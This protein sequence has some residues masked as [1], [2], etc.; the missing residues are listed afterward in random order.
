MDGLGAI[1]IGL[2]TCVMI[3]RVWQLVKEFV[4]SYE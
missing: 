3:G 1:A 2:V 4:S